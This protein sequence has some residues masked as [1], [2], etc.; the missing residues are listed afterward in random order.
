MISTSFTKVPPRST[1]NI[2][3]PVNVFITIIVNLVRTLIVF[4]LKM[5][6]VWFWLLSI[7][8]ASNIASFSLLAP[9]AGVFSGWLIFD[10]PLTLGFMAS[11]GLVLAGL[12]LANRPA[13]AAAQAR[14]PGQR[15]A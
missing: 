15:D 6:L 12:M 11:L 3:R 14:A 7:Y 13:G 4:I 10:D 2:I 5:R 8:P 9:L 1:T